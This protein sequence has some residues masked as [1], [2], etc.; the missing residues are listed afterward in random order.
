MLELIKN[1]ESE[2]IIALVGVVVLVGVIGFKVVQLVANKI[3]S[4][5]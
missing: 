1:L 3:Y 2:Q 4:L 5:K